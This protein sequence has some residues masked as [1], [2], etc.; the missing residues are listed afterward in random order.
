M[1]NLGSHAWRIAAVVS[2]S[3]LVSAFFLPVGGCHGEMPYRETRALWG[4]V[5]AGPYDTWCAYRYD[6]VGKWRA[7]TLETLNRFLTYVPP[8]VFGVLLAIAGTAR[9][10]RWAL[11]ERVVTHFAGGVLGLVC[12]VVLACT[13]M[14]QYETCTPFG[15]IRFSAKWP[16]VVPCVL[17]PCAILVYLAR[18]PKRSPSAYWCYAFIGSGATA[19][20]AAGWVLGWAMD[21]PGFI[22]V[23]SGVGVVLVASLVLILCT[24]GE[25]CSLSDQ[26][27]GRTLLR[28]T[29]GTFDLRT[30]EFPLCP[31]CGYCLIA[32][33][34][35]RCPE[36]GRPF[37]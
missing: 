8:F 26:S 20:W 1:D 27:W 37:S 15:P 13:W 31:E 3:V 14:R 36:C 10:K 22:E 19:A 33:P 34:E 18:V 29:V 21:W 30:N 9:L 25:A 17:I 7:W 5:R 2:A 4:F 28:L 16:F 24:V 12:L 32:L 35:K 6:T 11:V 23:R